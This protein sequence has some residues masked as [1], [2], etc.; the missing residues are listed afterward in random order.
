M[1]GGDGMIRFEPLLDIPKILLMLIFDFI[2]ILFDL[3]NSPHFI[4]SLNSIGLTHGA[5][6]HFIKT[7][8]VLVVVVLDVFCWLWLVLDIALFRLAWIF[9]F[10]CLAQRCE[11]MDSSE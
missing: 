8:T 5:F 3:L 10:L 7:S 6:N 4:V 11:F 2:N 9:D 1:I